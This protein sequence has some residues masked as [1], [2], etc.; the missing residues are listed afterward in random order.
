VRSKKRSSVRKGKYNDSK[1]E[2]A[3]RGCALESPP[4]EGPRRMKGAFTHKNNSSWG[5]SYGTVIR[6]IG[7]RPRGKKGI[8]FMK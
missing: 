1:E 3:F 6:D 4:E 8:F 7:A 5:G 2:R